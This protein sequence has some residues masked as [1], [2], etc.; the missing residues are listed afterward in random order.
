[1]GLVGHYAFCGA[2]SILPYQK[3]CFFPV[4]KHITST[5]ASYKLHLTF[6]KQWKKNK[7][8]SV[9]VVQLMSACVRLWISCTTPK[10]WPQTCSFFHCLF[11]GKIVGDFLF[12]L[13]CHPDQRG[14]PHDGGQQQRADEGAPRVPGVGER[15]LGAPLEGRWGEGRKQE[16]GHPRGQRTISQKQSEKCRIHF[17][18]SK[19]SR[20][21]SCPEAPCLCSGTRRLS[22]R[23]QNWRS[24]GLQLL[25]G[26]EV[27][28][29]EKEEGGRA[30][31]VGKGVEMST[32][33]FIQYSVLL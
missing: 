23:G 15:V 19:I 8:T 21:L 2:D 4:L 7:S 1:M 10:K 5:T 31:Q 29:I 30:P 9:Q 20:N 26:Q 12:L 13:N 6:G 24:K 33:I 14:Q 16:Q 25:E 11:L 27:K 17:H 28:S 3:S 18:L 32:D 22:S